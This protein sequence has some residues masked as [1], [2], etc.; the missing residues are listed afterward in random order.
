MTITVPPETTTVG[1]IIADEVELP[2][3]LEAA[4]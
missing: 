4:A 1:N 3:V 2:R